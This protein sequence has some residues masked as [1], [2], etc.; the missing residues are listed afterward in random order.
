MPEVVVIVT[1]NALQKL[2]Y[3]DFSKQ[4]SLFFF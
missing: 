2:E 3:L 4:E 1:C